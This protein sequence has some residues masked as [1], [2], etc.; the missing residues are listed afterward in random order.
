LKHTKTTTRWAATSDHS[1]S[2]VSTDDQF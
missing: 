2:T 1:L